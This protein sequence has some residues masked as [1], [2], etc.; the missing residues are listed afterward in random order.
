MQKITPNLWF[1]NKVKKAT[2][3]YVLVFPGSQITGGSTSPSSSAEG[4]AGFQKDLARKPLTVDSTLTGHNFV[5]INAGSELQPIPA[6]LCKLR[7]GKRQK[8]S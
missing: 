3:F 4:L 7:S 8:D 6:H 1:D 2:D 5:A